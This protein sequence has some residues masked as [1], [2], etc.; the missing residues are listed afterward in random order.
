MGR[1]LMTALRV[2][3]L[4]LLLFGLIYPLVMTALGQLIFPFKVNGSLIHE[5]SV[6][7]GSALIGQLFTAPRYFH[8]RPSAAGT[9]YDGRVSGG[10]NLGPTS[11]ALHDRVAADVKR[12]RAEN[13][14]LG[15][16]PVDMVTTSGSGLDADITLANALAQVPRVAA[17]RGLAVYVVRQLVLRHVQQRQLG[18]F[19]EPRINVLELN[20]ALDEARH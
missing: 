17:A 14:G 11:K 12:L 7:R 18:I 2:S 1:Y 9:G 6:V 8:P 19:G 13:P 20:R 3:L 10:S 5:G 4:T 16:V 15:A